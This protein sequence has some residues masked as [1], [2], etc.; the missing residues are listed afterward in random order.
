MGYFVTLIYIVACGSNLFI[1]ITVLNF[2]LWIYYYI[3]YYIYMSVLL[4]KSILFI[5][6]F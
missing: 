6:R 3:I 5:S 4:F 2:I 1:F